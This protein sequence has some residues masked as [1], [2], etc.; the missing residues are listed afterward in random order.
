MSLFQTK[1]WNIAF[2]IW[3]GIPLLNVLGMISITVVVSPLLLLTPSPLLLW[4]GFRS[5]FLFVAHASIYEN[6][7]IITSKKYLFSTH[8]L[9]LTWCILRNCSCL[10]C[11]ISLHEAQ[12]PQLTILNFVGMMYVSVYV[13]LRGWIP[14]PFEEVQIMFFLCFSS[15]NWWDNYF[16]KDLFCILG[17]STHGSVHSLCL[18]DQW[19]EWGFV[20]GKEK[21]REK[22]KSLKSLIQRQP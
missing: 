1:S 10:T 14:S 17:N 6:H 15:F 12:N 2:T 7:E 20:E 3:N 19:F 4:R 9:I 16:E 13:I 8:G 5:C 22:W 11:T 18:L 21:G